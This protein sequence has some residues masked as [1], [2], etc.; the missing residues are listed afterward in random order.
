[1]IESYS[2][3]VYSSEDGGT[4]PKDTSVRKE[5]RKTSG[6]ISD[7]LPDD[8]DDGIVRL[9]RGRA[10]RRGKPRT[11]ITGLPGKDSDLDTVLKLC[12]QRL[13]TGG[14]RKNR[15]LMIQGDH[16]HKL[17]TMLE[18]DGYVVKIVGQ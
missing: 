16:R 3:L 1:M 17:Q 18:T 11:L 12:K 4:I 9:H 13:G 8:P 2:R 5:R 7:R 10:E 15:I 6:S 14:T